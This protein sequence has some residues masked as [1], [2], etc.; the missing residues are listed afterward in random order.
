MGKQRRSVNVAD[1][2]T[3]A[4]LGEQVS[5]FPPKELPTEEPLAVKSTCFHHVPCYT[6]LW[7]TYRSYSIWNPQERRL[8]ASPI[9][10][11]SASHGCILY[12]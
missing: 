10:S 4:H 8:L 3:A 7:A 6:Q 12:Q 9:A 2:I 1:E 5:I 11:C